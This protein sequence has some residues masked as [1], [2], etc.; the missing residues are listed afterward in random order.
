MQSLEVFMSRLL[1]LVPGCPDPTARQALLDSAIEFCEETNAVQTVTEPATLTA[2]KSS[3][4]LDIPTQT[5]V[6][7]VVRAWSGKRKLRLHQAMKV[8][9]PLVYYNPDGSYYAPEA[10]PTAVTVTDNGVATLYPTPDTATA[11]GELLTVRIATKP[12]RTATQVDDDLYRS[13]AEAV[14]AG[15][16]FRLAGMP[17]TAFSDEAQAQKALARYRYF[18]NRARIESNRGRVGGSAAVRST[19]FA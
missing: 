17:G 6:A 7:R 4:D 15:A 11:A 16:M 3:Y 14:V 13:W 19:P 12:S 5:E 1:P 10:P 18:I 8:D 9:T 2:G